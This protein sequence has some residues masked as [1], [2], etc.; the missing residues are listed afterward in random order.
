MDEGNGS[1]ARRG[2]DGKG[3]AE[4]IRYAGETY[5]DIARLFEEQPKHDWEPLGDLLHIYKGIL[6]AFPDI[7]SVHK[8]AIQKRKECERMT[9]EHKMEQ[10][11]YQQVVHR[12]DVVSYALLAEIN[13][14]HAE[15]STQIKKAMKNFLCEQAAFYQKIAAKLQDAYALFEDD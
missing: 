12:T 8:D 10:S 7:L 2:T 4:A 11:Q 15:R 1:N 14:F 3:L 13:H 5:N 6:A 9:L